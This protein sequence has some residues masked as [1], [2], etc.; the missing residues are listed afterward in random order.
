MSLFGRELEGVAVW[1]DGVAV[2]LWP[3]V[4]PEVPCEPVVV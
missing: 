3:V 4:L 1:L 2:W